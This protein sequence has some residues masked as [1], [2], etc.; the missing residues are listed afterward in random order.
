MNEPRLASSSHHLQTIAIADMEKKQSRYH[1]QAALDSACS[2]PSLYLSS[3]EQ[4]SKIFLSSRYSP[5]KE[6][7]RILKDTKALQETEDTPASMVIILGAANLALVSLAARSYP[8]LPIM[9][10]AKDSSLLR[11]SLQLLQT[12]SFAIERELIVDPSESNPSKL[13]NK[14]YSAKTTA[15][16]G[17]SQ[18]SLKPPA[19]WL[20]FLLKRYSS[21]RILFLENR[22]ETR[23]HQKFF[24]WLRSEVIRHQ[25]QKAVN[26]FTFSRFEKLWL[27]NLCYNSTA[28]MKARPFQDLRGLGRGM[29]LV[30]VGA[31]PSLDHDIKRLQAQQSKVAIIASDTAYG[32]LCQHGISA[33]FVVS[34]DPQKINAMYLESLSAQDKL[35]TSLLAEASISP[36]GMRGFKHTFM[37]DGFYP[38]Y[39]FLSSIFGSKGSIE[40]GG[41]VATVCFKLALCMEFSSICLLGVDLSYSLHSYHAKGSLH[42]ERWFSRCNKLNPYDSLIM[43]LYAKDDLQYHKNQQGE[44]VFTDAAMLL[45]REWFEEQAL[46]AENPKT[47]TLI[48]SATQKKLSNASATGLPMSGIPYKTF[49]DFIKEIDRPFLRSVFRS[50]LDEKASAYALQQAELSPSFNQRLSIF[51]KAMVQLI[52]DLRLYQNLVAKSLSLLSKIIQR[53]K[54][55]GM[56]SFNK[57]NKKLLAELESLEARLTNNTL[58]KNFISA[59]MQ[60]TI[61]ETSDF[62]LENFTKESSHVESFTL[63]DPWQKA[64]QTKQKLFLEMQNSCRFNEKSL[65]SVLHLPEYK[66]LCSQHGLHVMAH[67]P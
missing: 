56:H 42:E 16:Y 6:A 7:S 13:N 9:V 59:A 1:F 30:I 44:L 14:E 4:E 18:A 21:K 29:P 53:S 57:A 28:I 47:P 66:K 64:L 32:M 22:R 26:R 49:Q 48:P 19:T 67:L 39:Q 46:L 37:F 54:N 33:D 43:P 41:S 25:T 27:K 55:Q 23:L 3:K 15:L 50:Q 38:Y 65:L 17:L 36:A 62:S 24:T 11:L 45:Y 61:F 34:I 58:V 5:E 31:G 20:E 10:M 35:A 52:K 8:A 63:K 60:K 51:H 12:S 2:Y 40:V